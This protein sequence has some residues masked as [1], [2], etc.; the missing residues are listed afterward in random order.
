MK[1]VRIASLVLALGAVAA[2]TPA[3]AFFHHH[4]DFWAEWKAANAK[5]PICGFFNA[6]FHIKK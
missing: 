5:N 6:V 1:L 4:K 2:T 3:S